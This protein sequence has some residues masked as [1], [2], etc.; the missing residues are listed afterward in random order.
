MAVDST[1][2]RIIISFISKSNHMPIILNFKKELTVESRKSYVQDVICACEE[3]NIDRLLEIAH[4][5]GITDQEEGLFEGMAN[6]RDKFN[7]VKAEGITSLE[8]CNTLCM[9]CY[10]AEEVKAFRHGNKLHF[11]IKFL[12]EEGILQGFM[13][14]KYYIQKAISDEQMDMNKTILRCTIFEGEE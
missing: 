13:F 11:A 4:D 9:G 10:K 5:K 8:A 12:E 7:A 1:P 3:L 6:I 14:C 2:V